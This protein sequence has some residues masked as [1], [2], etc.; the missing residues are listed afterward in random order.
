MI[1]YKRVTF[2]ILFSVTGVIV[3]SLASNIFTSQ[4][5]YDL[6]AVIAVAY[7]TIYIVNDLKGKS[8]FETVAVFLAYTARFTL[9]ISDIYFDDILNILKTG[10]GDS[11]GFFNVSLEHFG[12]NFDIYYTRY[13]YVL[14]F[15]YHIFGPKRIVPQY[16]N[17]VCWYF[18]WKLIYRMLDGCNPRQKKIMTALFCFI[19]ANV[20]MTSELLRES[21]MMLSIMWSFFFLWKWM[22][23]GFI[24]NII[25]AYL[26]SIPAVLLH[27][28]SIALWA[29]IMFVY[30]FWNYRLQKWGL[31]KGKV[32]LGILGLLVVYLF[33]HYK[34]YHMLGY[35]PQELSLESITGRKF[36]VGRADYLEDIIVTNTPQLIFWTIIRGIYFW[37]SP[38]IFDW[39]S[40]KDIL[41]V[42][43]DV[44]PL[45]YI[46][47]LIFRKKPFEFVNKQYVAGI[48]ILILYTLVYAWGVRNAGGA[49]R[50]RNMLLGLLI[51][52]Y[53]IRYLPRDKILEK[54]RIVRKGGFQ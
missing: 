17:V 34:I 23:S 48:I 54:E 31:I 20:F 11:E 44:I 50:H 46:I 22:N 21:I 19:P 12:G 42:L 38:V 32:F 41:G 49:M 14:N 26:I 16:F 28:V 39:N 51:M 40:I 2:A 18:C 29:G 52:T 25:I 43:T 3:F 24:Q 45:V 35:F 27:S 33:F 37:I 8:R 7:G 5:I 47:F 10:G 15:F 13:P 9:L 1:R 36:V 4:I 30:I 6:I 53:G